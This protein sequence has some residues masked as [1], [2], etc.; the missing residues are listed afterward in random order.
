VKSAVTQLLPNRLQNSAH[1]ADI[2]EAS[3]KSRKK[4]TNMNAKAL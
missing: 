3:L 1:Y 4:T 2:R